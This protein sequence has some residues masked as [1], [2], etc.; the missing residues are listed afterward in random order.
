VADRPKGNDPAVRALAL[1]SLAGDC[2]KWGDGGTV[3]S[4]VDILRG[5]HLNENGFEIAKDLDRAYR[6]TGIDAELVEIL[7]GA[8]SH[9]WSAHRDAVQ[10]WAAAEGVKPTLAIGQRIECRYGR[11]VINGIDEEIAVY[12]LKPDGEE[13]RFSQGGG[14]HV[15]YETATLIDQV[16]A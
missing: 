5:V 4:W 12:L 16:P 3:D 15:A 11:G 1:R 9:L 6:V 14:V 7:D 13:D 8:S 2:A 10:A